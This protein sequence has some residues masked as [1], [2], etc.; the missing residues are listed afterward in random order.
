MD[1]YE[2]VRDQLDTLDNLLD[3]LVLSGTGDVRESTIKEIIKLQKYCKET[4]MKGCSELLQ[5]LQ[6]A[7]SH[8]RHNLGAGESSIVECCCMLGEYSN[9]ARLKLTLCIIN[10]G[11]SKEYK[12][13]DGGI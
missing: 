5:Q 6:K 1:K 8:R 13:E 10:E 12:I 4:G 9:A 11:L 2:R 3:G 7:I